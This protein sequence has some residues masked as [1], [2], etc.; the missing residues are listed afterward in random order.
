MPTTVDFGKA[1]EYACLATMGV[2]LSE[3]GA[4]VVTDKGSA[5]RT[6]FDC[7][8]RLEVA[9]Q[10]NMWNAAMAGVRYVIE[11]EPRLWNPKQEPISLRLQTDSAGKQGDVRDLLCVRMKGP[12][13]IGISCK[14]NHQAVKHPRLSGDIDFGR[15][16]LKHPCSQAYFNQVRPIFARLRTLQ[17]AGVLWEDL[18]DKESIYDQILSAFCAELSRLYH[19]HTAEVPARLVQYLIGTD[20]FYKIVSNEVDKSTTIQ[21]F[22]FDDSLNAKA[23][24]VRP[25]IK[26]HSQ[27]LPTKILS[28]ARKSGSKTTMTVILDESWTLSFRIH[29]AKKEVEPSL[30][31]DVELLGVP[32]ALTKAHRI[33]ADVPSLPAGLEAAE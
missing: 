2:C 8:L 9:A 33:W 16:W 27:K 30:K 25:A 22:N 5:F 3:K 31:F 11:C 18:E 28:I 14:H 32:A 23:G 12:W 7:F 15:D 20:S 26:I 1:F 4:T 17:Q 19:Q 6:A 29:N 24:S 13:E 10:R 21:A